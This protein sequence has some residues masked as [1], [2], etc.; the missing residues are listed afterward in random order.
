MS[1]KKIFFV[2]IALFLFQQT[3]AQR[4]NIRYN[5]LGLNGGVS[6]FDINTDD[7]VTFQ[8]T[9]F[10]GGFTT[11]G[12]FYDDFDIIY[13]INYFNSKVAVE[14]QGLTGTQEIEYSIQGAQLNLLGSYNIAVKHLS[15][16]FGP[17]FQVN[18]KMKLADD[19]YGEYIVTGY[20]TLMASE[21]Q[22]ISRINL[23]AAV[24]LTAGVEHFRIS[25]Q[26]HYG[27]TNMLNKLNDKNLENNDFKGNSSTIVVAAVIYF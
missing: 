16:E 5:L 22:D 19:K 21:I 17:I 27:L 11:R 26:Y 7:L 13:G 9:G 14:G 12:A 3:F 15:V 25:G 4:G 8:K 1:L 10:T 18:S 23:L 24:G 20:N 6:F 2:A